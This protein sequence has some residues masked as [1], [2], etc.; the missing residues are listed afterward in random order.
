MWKAAVKG[1]C[2]QFLQWRLLKSRQ[3]RSLS[4]PSCFAHENKIGGK[5]WVTADQVIPSS[6][7]YKANLRRNEDWTATNL[8]YDETKTGRRRT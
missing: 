7:K 8:M 6:T 4:A 3:P 5:C 2:L 1:F